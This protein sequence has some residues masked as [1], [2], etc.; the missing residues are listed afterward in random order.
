[1]IEQMA[2]L[3]CFY[4]GFN[5]DLGGVLV[6]LSVAVEC[7]VNARRGDEIFVELPAYRYSRTK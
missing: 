5:G 1:M 2:K 4:V 3:A 7:S 6:L